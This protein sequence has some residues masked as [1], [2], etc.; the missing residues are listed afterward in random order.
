MDARVRG[1]D[2]RLSTG[3]PPRR[4]AAALLLAVLAAVLGLGGLAAPAA[5]AAVP[6]TRVTPTPAPPDDADALPVRVEIT[7]VAPTVLRPGED[8]VVTARL[9]NTSP[10]P[11]ADP[12]VLVHLER[13]RPGTRDD[14]QRWLDEPVTGRRV[15]DRVAQQQAQGPLEP[16][17]SLDVTLTVAAGNVGLLDRPDT[18]GA[19]GLS[20]QATSGGRRVGLQRT[21]ALWAT[22]SDDVPQARV[23]LLVPVVGPA[24]VPEGV[25]LTA[26][27]PTLGELVQP[28]HRLDAALETARSSA[29][30]ALVV[31]PALLD[32]AR[33]GT[34]Q[35]AA[36]ADELT[37]V[38]VGRD[39]VALPW[40]D[41]DLTALAHAGALDLL[42]AATDATDAAAT[43]AVDGGRRLSA[44]TDVLWAP[45]PLTDRATVDLAARSGASVLVMAPGDL[46]ADRDV[47]GARTELAS[48][49]G[50][51]LG[52]V[53][54]ATLT[55]LLTD[56]AR[57]VPDAT[58]ATVVQ[59]VL[60]ELSVLARGSPQGLQ[61][62]LVALPRD[63]VPDPARIEAVLS[64]VQAAPWS[65]T[66]P[67]TALLGASGAD[68]QRGAPPT[69][70][71]DPDALGTAQVER[72][73]AA[74]R[75][76][77]AFAAV[78]D[79][80]ARLLT[81]VDQEVLAPLATAWRSD[82]A[83]RDR[84]VDAV[85]AVV[86]A[87]RSGLTLA[88]TSAQYFVSADN[89]VRFS[90]R[91]E[92][93]A[94]AR[95]RVQTVP[96]K[97]CL[98]TEPSDTV[99]VRAGGEEVVTVAMHAIANCDVVVEAVLTSADGV[100]L[101]EP[102]TFDVRATPTIESVGTA[103]VG[104][105]LAVGLVLGVVRTVR[106]GQSARR[107]ARRVDD[108]AGTRPLPVLGGTP[109]GDSR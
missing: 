25:E 64:A 33:T 52:I 67:L 47:T 92:L 44:R 41:P 71:T 85:V 66:A 95:V 10:E 37:S 57:L 76:T 51:V 73:A 27:G 74:R 40:S 19:R 38:A 80:P 78:T 1:T 32:A 101:A 72:L 109:E 50:T 97:A 56:P 82:P 26:P 45:G 17:A 96:R 60:A 55:T 84:L 100:P 81:G 88:R 43:A 9:T 36:W 102:V 91:N 4:T 103:V 49:G 7:E 24:A 8:L 87:R 98:R 58:D 62:V 22:E 35:A 94:D 69:T 107:G 48:P 70:L 20:V 46:P 53:P 90:V 105:L 29:D 18:W 93:P 6:T 12:R 63:A 104:V 77:V 61:H 13:I 86:D 59:R 54:D 83:G 28:G 3:G 42:D 31:D 2:P 34:S 108:E 15:G 5:T 99:A 65:R 39:V 23:S 89:T 75:A 106:R 68:E 14:L 79:E 16:G 11:V 21:F 30:V